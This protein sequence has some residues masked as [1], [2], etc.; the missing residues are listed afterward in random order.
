MLHE[1]P[2]R[3]FWH[4]PILFVLPSIMLGIAKTLVLVC[5]FTDNRKAMIEIDADRDMT[6]VK[7]NMVFEL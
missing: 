3:F 7:K 5:I 2:K 6:H 1:S 4:L